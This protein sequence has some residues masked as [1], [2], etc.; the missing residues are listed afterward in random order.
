MGQTFRSIIPYQTCIDPNTSTFKEIHLYDVV[1]G[2]KTG[3]FSF[4]GRNWTF[5]REFFEGSYCINNINT[6]EDDASGNPIQKCPSLAFYEQKVGNTTIS[7]IVNKEKDSICNNPTKCK[8]ILP[9]NKSSQT[10]DKDTGEIK[11]ETY[12]KTCN[13]TFDVT[14][15]NGNKIEVK[16]NITISESP[17]GTFWFSI[18]GSEDVR[19]NS[20]GEYAFDIITKDLLSHVVLKREHLQKFIIMSDP[21]Q[22]TGLICKTTPSII[23]YDKNIKKYIIYPTE[24]DVPE[25][26]LADGDYTY[27][28]EYGDYNPIYGLP[29]GGSVSDTI[30]TCVEYLGS[31]EK[32]GT[33][34]NLLNK[35]YFIIKVGSIILVIVLS[36]LDFA[37]STTKSK[38]ELMS[39]VK[40]LVNRL[41]ILVIILLLPTFIDMIGNIIGMEDVLCGIK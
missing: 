6:Y 38:D 18:D 35:V 25:E 27:G 12:N 1:L 20:S 13:Y 16:T 15:I 17:K 3:F 31:A 37:M 39:T 28:G 26:E 7:H 11:E 19:L 24:E 14:N 9:R 23:K 41:I 36:M 34:A 5:K 21:D 4:A 22:G 8:A 10:V 40:K 33:I 29:F 30:S 32:D 2:G